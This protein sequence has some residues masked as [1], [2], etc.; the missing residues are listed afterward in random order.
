[1][2][3]DLQRSGKALNESIN[4]EVKRKIF[5]TLYGKAIEMEAQYGK[6]RT[7]NLIDRSKEIAELVSRLIDKLAKDYKTAIFSE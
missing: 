3:N 7:G 4:V 2:K 6:N 1:M 5:W